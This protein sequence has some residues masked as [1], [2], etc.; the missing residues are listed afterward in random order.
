MSHIKKTIN[1]EKNLTVIT[2]N[3]ELTFDQIID[4]LD[5]FYASEYTLY[6]LWDLTNADTSSLT[7]VQVDMI[8]DHAKEYAHLR[9]GGKAAFV[10]SRDVD[11]GLARM[12][13]QL[14]E[15]KQHPIL[16]GVFRSLDEAMNW[17]ENK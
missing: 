5:Q 10:L 6:L 16:H 4:V 17:L 15:A 1:R 2:V 11:F 3:G 8:V 7:T 9:K 14:S 12:Y 13:E